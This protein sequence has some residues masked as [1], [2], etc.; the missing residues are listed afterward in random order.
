M[1]EEFKT[2]EDFQICNECYKVTQKYSENFFVRDLM[3]VHLSD[4]NK[5]KSVEEKMIVLANDAVKIR[6]ACAK[7]TRDQKIMFPK[8]FSG[9]WCGK[10]KRDLEKFLSRMYAK[11]DQL[12]YRLCRNVYCIKKMGEIDGRECIAYTIKIPFQ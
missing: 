7:C 1:E 3:L 6:E 12:G 8:V 5:I 11:A 10:S 4:K 2:E 9:N